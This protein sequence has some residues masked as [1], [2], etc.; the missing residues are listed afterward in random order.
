M[1]VML[2]IKMSVEQKCFVSYSF[3]VLLVFGFGGFVWV[4]FCQEG[5]FLGL[6]VHVILHWLEI[7]CGLQELLFS[8]SF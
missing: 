2:S 6:Q 8:F 7:G 3:S 5:L 4:L 1:G